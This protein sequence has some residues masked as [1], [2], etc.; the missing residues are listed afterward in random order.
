[1]ILLSFLFIP[2]LTALLLLFIK[3]NQLAQ[4]TA[5]LFSLLTLFVA[6][7]M[8]CTNVVDFNAAWLPNLNSRF[9]LHA[10]GLSK[11][12]IVLTAISIPA[13]LIAT[14]TNEYKQR[15]IF[16]A[17]LLFTQA[18]L[19]GVFLAGDA[20]L[21]YFF[22][23]LA[24]IPVYFLCSIWGG[25]KRIAI[26]FKFFIYT[27]LGSLFMLV[28]IL[29]LNA[30]TADHSFL[31]RSFMSANLSAGQ[32]ITAFALF[33]IAFA[34]KMPLFP[35][36]T[37]QPDAYEQSPTA[38]TMVLSAVMVKM[39]LYGVIRW[40]A[41]LFPVAFMA[42]TH[43]VVVLSIIGILYAS[44]IAIRQDDLKRLIAYSSIAHIGLMNAAL[45]THTQ[46]ATQGALI[47]LFSHGINVLGLW[48]V[49]DIIEQ[50]T[51]TRSM[52][53][54]GGLAKKQPVLAILLVGF[55]LANMALPLTNSFV[56]E[57]LMFTGLFQFNPWM[58]AFAGVSVVLAAI[59]TL[60]MVQKV[61]Y[62]AVSEK[63]NTMQGSNKGA[64]AVLIILLMI[65][66]VTGVFPK[67]LFTLTADTLQQLFVK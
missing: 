37:W 54:M 60:N 16:L 42:H 62:G 63:I 25:E 18:G 39:G 11:I 55:A 48:M 58:A 36:H 1:M 29:F 52:Q 5:I 67:P 30:H 66:L 47:Q 28:G 38:V 32:Q 3:N 8:L 7:G 6:L 35:L 40:L 20:L 13:I 64:Q 50:Q 65:V 44:F 41:P 27:F 57:F 61:A 43:V 45:F 26:T 2:I 34:I 19:M 10:D 33:F 31:I 14:A 51:G 12:L 53:Q 24:L 56:G 22:W 49:A 21:F 9:V 15:N 23:E 17:L 59:Y 46:I 4:R